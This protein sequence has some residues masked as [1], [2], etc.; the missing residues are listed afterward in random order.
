MSILYCD[1]LKSVRILPIVFCEART[2]TDLTYRGTPS[3]HDHIVSYEDMRTTPA[4]PNVGCRAHLSASPFSSTVNPSP[5][6]KYL[7]C[8]I[9][10]TYI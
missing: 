4:S 3:G 2:D 10:R 8:A 5:A 1:S 9:S 6:L 7:L